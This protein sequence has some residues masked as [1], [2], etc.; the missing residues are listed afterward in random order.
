MTGRR[1]NGLRPVRSGEDPDLYRNYPRTVQRAG[2]G[3]S[4]L[5]Q[6]PALIHSSVPETELDF[7]GFRF[8]KTVETEAFEMPAPLTP[9]CTKPR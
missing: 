9:G 6:P 7:S 2:A 4:Q 5:M 8:R 1:R 3:R